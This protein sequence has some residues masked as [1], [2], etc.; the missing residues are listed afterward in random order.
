[1][2]EIIRTV[3]GD[4]APGE[5]GMTSMHE[6]TLY[7]LRHLTAKFIPMLPPVPEERTKYKVENLA[8][9]RGG[10]SYYSMDG[11]HMDDVDYMAR[12]LGFFKE[13]GGNSICDCSPSCM[14]GSVTDMARLSRISGIQIV[15]STGLYTNISRPDKYRGWSELQMAEFFEKEALEG[16]DGT[17]IKAGILKSAVESVDET[18][19][20][21]H[22]EEL[23]VV[24]AC[25]RVA[26]KTGMPMQIHCQKPV[27]PDAILRMVDM[28]LSE[29]GVKPEK[30]L[31]CHM[32]N[33][34]LG[35]LSIEEYVTKFDSFRVMSHKLHDTVL[36]MGV[37]IGL[38]TWGMPME[39]P[40][41]MIQD[42]QDHLKLLYYLLSNGYGGQ[43][44]LGHDFC[45]Y[46]TS[47]QFGGYGMTRW[48]EYAVG[49]CR[50]FGIP[51]EELRKP[52]YE[53]PAR[54]LAFEPPRS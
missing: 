34:L 14:R 4:I 33:Y 13:L 47:R 40:S 54:L 20:Y 9:L 16:I 10:G 25:A 46:L 37:N 18:G 43:V 28:I 2:A 52:V 51:E 36:K 1:M 23:V 32:G 19:K 8:F 12:E 38:D 44:V 7:D 30:V 35:N 24:R 50:Q 21:I 31:L 39:N 26:A 6:H 49:M 11:A 15:C 27:Q 45:G 22:P 53:T 5:L 42:D 17:G 29:Y 48:P 3:C 41:M